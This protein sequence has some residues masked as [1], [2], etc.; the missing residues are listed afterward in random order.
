TRMRKG[1]KVKRPIWLS[2]LC[3]SAALRLCVKSVRSSLMFAVV[4]LFAC[5]AYFAVNISFGQTPAND[6]FSNRI[7]LSGTNITVTGSNKKATK[8]TGE[9]NHAGNPGGASVW[10]RWSAPTNGDLIITTDGSDFDTLLG[11]YT[12][13]SV[14]ALSVI[15]SNDDHSVLDT[16]R[17]RFEAIG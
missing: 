2:T 10:W 6:Q 11:I 14:S 12:G 15:I 1:A 4:R 16:S 8:E 3:V 9:P 5:F 7:V 17:V 13:S